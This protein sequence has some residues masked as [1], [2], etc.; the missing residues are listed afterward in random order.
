MVD[1]YQRDQY[2]LASKFPT[3]NLPSEDQVE[4]IFLEQLDKCG[5][6]YFD[7]YLLH[8]LNRILYEIEVEKNHLFDYMKKWKTEGKIKHI[9]F[10]YH[11]DATHL[12]QILTEHPEVEVVQIVMNYYDDNE[13][14]IQGKACYDVIR[15]HGCQVIIMEPVKGGA[16]V[17]IPQ[18]AIE[19][20]QALYPHAST[21]SYAIRYCASYD[22]VVAVLS[23]MS[24]MEQMQDNISY[25]LDFQSLTKEEYDILAYTKQEIIKTWKYQCDDWSVLDDN[26]YH[27]PL[28]AI[29][30][31]Y[32]S[33]LIQPIPTFGA[34]LNYYKTFRSGY[35]RAFE[36]ADYSW[37]NSKI[38]NAFDVNTALQEAI[39]FL[40]ENSF[41]GYIED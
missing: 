18:T 15:K 36:K 34:E 5:V 23:G 27:V 29:M 21:A 39:N 30:R 7:Y 1:R 14:M 33:L 38:N 2:V 32:N 10:S 22:G 16:L 20:M 37:L 19:K 41:Q 12:D 40:T 17:N 26:D 35:D 6:E 4:S 11:D 31:S 9:G 25:M 13:S 24:N 3:F 28:S 8:N